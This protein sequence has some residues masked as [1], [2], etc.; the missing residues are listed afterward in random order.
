MNVRRRSIGFL[1]PVVLPINT[2]EQLKQAFSEPR[3]R[4]LIEQR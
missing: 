4:T 1:A 3:Q 2:E